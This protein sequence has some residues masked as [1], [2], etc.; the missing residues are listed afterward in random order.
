[1][2]NE[3]CI[4]LLKEEIET[5]GQI[6]LV[7]HGDSMLPLLKDGDTIKIEKCNEYKIGDVVAYIL[8][9]QEGFKVIIHRIVF[10][11]KIYV[12]TRGDNN[13]FIDDRVL[14]N[15]ILGILVN[16]KNYGD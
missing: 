12:L 11:R 10:V 3:L 6:Q 14:K 16:K 1:M 7:V 2:D 15:N 8:K 13:D 9:Q 4:R 5:K